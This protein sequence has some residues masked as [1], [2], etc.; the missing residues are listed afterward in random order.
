MLPVAGAALIRIAAYPP[1]LSLPSWPDLSADHP[2]QWRAWLTEVWALPGFADAVTGAAP[3]LAERIAVAA[4]GAALPLRRWRRLVDTVMRYLL[5]WTTRATPFGM[6]AGVAPVSFAERTT[7]HLG[8]AHRAVAHPD[9]QF[10]AEHATQAEHDLAMLHATSVVANTL[11]YRRGEKWVLPCAGTD[12]DRRWDVE[13]RLA[14][15]VQT[16]LDAARSPISFTDLAAKVGASMPAAERLLARLIDLGVLLTALRPATT[17]T[18]PGAHLA[19]HHLPFDPGRRAAVDLRADV[20]VALPPA[21]LREASRAAQ[22]LTAIAPALPGWQEYHAA[23]IDRWGP[24]VA[25]PLREVLGTLGF[26]AGYRGSTRRSPATFTPRDRLL[27]RLAQQAALDDG[28]EVVLDDD[29]IDQLHGDDDRSPIPHTEL[30]FTLAA[31]TPADVDR[32]AFTLTV[33]SGSRHAGTAAGRFLHLLDPDELVAFRTVYRHLPTAQPGADVVQLSGP[34]LDARLAPLTRAPEL[35]PILP[36]GEFHPAPV[37]TVDDLAI[38]GDGRQL[39]LVSRTTGQPVEPLLFN[40]VLLTTLQQPLMRFLTEIWTAWTAP[41]APFD[42]GHAHDLPYLPRV[43]RGRSILHPARWR[44]DRTALPTWTAA[45]LQWYDSWQRHRHQYHL[46]REVLVG[47]DDVRVRLDLDNPAHLHLLR[48]ELDRQPHADLTEAPGPAGW[49]DGRPAELVLTLT[50]H[51]SA[52]RIPRQPRPVTTL[53]HRPGP[54]RWVQAHLY[55]PTDEILADLARRPAD[56]L[57]AGW[58]FLRYP[59]PAAHLRLRIP[60]TDSDHFTELAHRLADWMQQ[61][62][63]TGAAYD[64]SLHPYR[65]E[66]RHGAHATLAAAEAFFATDSRAALHRLIA[67]RDRQASTAAGMIAIATAFTSDGP[68]WLTTHVPH[69]TGPR[70]NREQLAIAGTP[71][72]DEHLAGTL[73]AYRAAIDNDTLDVDTVLGDLLHL[74]HTRMI[75]VAAASEQHCLRLARAIAL[76]GRSR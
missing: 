25:V 73:T 49:I 20:E 29:L 59:T 50:R 17:V 64:Y 62:H 34:P 22:A 54:S 4:S 26:P 56:Y 7:V 10:V 68:Q 67:S 72:H 70:L 75:G 5:R 18:D 27:A 36:L 45:W 51:T 52:T 30:R 41:C 31:D 12:G 14:S 58:W 55:G 3:E 19:R 63:D 13:V 47:A 9:G 69:R 74:H 61:L 44:I 11:G 43:R 15:P 33:L 21:V 23:F 8:Q 1:G 24:G 16:A 65:P 39:W 37:R 28:A 46:P 6:F 2:A 76:A 60:V 71:V 53:I 32:G 40:S 48:H 38:T 57:P 35:L 42:W 66:A